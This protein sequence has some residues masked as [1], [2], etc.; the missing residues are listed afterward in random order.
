MAKAIKT[1]KSKAQLSTLLQGL[2]GV[3]HRLMEQWIN[4]DPIYVGKLDGANYEQSIKK[5]LIDSTKEIAFDGLWCEF[6]VKEGRSL[7]W[8]I[9]EYSDQP[10]HA[11]DSWEGLPEDWHNE[12]VGTYSSDGNIPQIEGGEFIVGKFEDTLPGFFAESRPM[13]SIINFDAD[14]YSSTICALNFAKRIFNVEPVGSH[15]FVLP[16]IEPRQ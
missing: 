11:F 10:I 15:G 2:D 4:Q 6:G 16:R 7:K 5:H 1:V 14:L 9:E 13:A 12:K 3:G 8:L